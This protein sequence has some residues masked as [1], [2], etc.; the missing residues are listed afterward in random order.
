M[1]NKIVY[2]P[3]PY[4]GQ[5]YN[6]F[7]RN[8]VNILKENYPV[9]GRWDPS[10]N[11]TS[12]SETK[13][14]ILNWTE[15][16]LTEEQ[17]NQILLYQKYGTK[18]IWFF[19]NRMSHEMENRKKESENMIW[20]ADHS[21][22]IVLLS[23]S[24]KQYIPGKDINKE[25]TEYIPHVLYRNRHNL[26]IEENF[27]RKYNLDGSEFVY[28]IFGMLRPYKNI[29][30]AIR[31]FNE[32]TDDDIRLIIAGEPISEE[33]GKELKLLIRGNEKIIYEPRFMS[34]MELDSL[35]ALFDIVLI[36]YAGQSSMNSGVLIKA[37]SNGKAVIAPDICMVRDINTNNDFLYR[38]E[39]NN[40]ETLKEQMARAYYDGKT[41]LSSKGENAKQYVDKHNNS[42][43]VKRLLEDLL[44]QTC[45][46]EIGHEIELS[47]S[48]NCLEHEVEWNAEGYLRYQYL[49]KV[50]CQ[51]MNQKNEKHKISEW[52]RR[53][54]WNKV[55]IYG[56]GNMG[57]ALLKELE[58]DE[59]K[60]LYGIDRNA[61]KIE[62]GIPVYRLTDKLERVDGIIVTAIT[63]YEE[64]ERELQNELDIPVVSLKDILDEIECLND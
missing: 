63:F 26:R 62:A 46:L 35:I 13:A 5:K 53:V 48:G 24:S 36:P 18:I 44:E 19:H 56:M 40:I 33:Y 15:Q 7:T 17:K 52:I 11:A 4:D 42:Q 60:V 50:M 23:K 41:E 43:I 8:M 16:K 20:L 14:I 38:W 22:T 6:E 32:L 45:D 49:F 47:D 25:K 55:A 1:K 37:L 12:I 64:I 9:T 28:G 30:T 57:K 10:L 3:Y 34:E 31:Y 21:D 58:A 54:N 61:E 27:K 59:V 2:L 29:E 51:W 39:R